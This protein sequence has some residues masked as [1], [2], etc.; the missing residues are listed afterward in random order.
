MKYALK[1][2][3]LDLKEKVASNEKALKDLI[4]KLSIEHEPAFSRKGMKLE[5]E[6]DRQGHDP[7]IPGYSSSISLGISDRNGE[8]IDLHSIKIW[9]CGRYFLGMPTSR[10]IPGSKI[11]GELI[12]GTFDEI[13]S[14]LKEYIAEQLTESKG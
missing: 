4:E 10:N 2:F 9:V 8:L 14:E 3:N 11:E 1:D 6:F 13:Q 12:D 5:A 7:F